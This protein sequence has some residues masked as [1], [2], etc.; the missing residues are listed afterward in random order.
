[1]KVVKMYKLLV[2]RRVNLGDVIPAWLLW[3]PEWL[4]LKVAMT[5]ERK[6]Y[7]HKNICNFDINV[8]TKIVAIISLYIYIY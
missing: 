1:M 6:S 3:L 2:I 4:Y 8:L 5:V 7:P